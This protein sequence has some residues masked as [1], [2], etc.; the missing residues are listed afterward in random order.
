MT[1]EEWLELEK[2]AE[3]FYDTIDFKAFVGDD[4]Q[5]S[6]RELMDKCIAYYEDEHQELMP[7]FLQGCFFNVHNEEEFCDYLACRYGAKNVWKEEVVT[8]YIRF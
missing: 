8:C 5:I 6:V 3:E 1:D 2:K 7:E 4:D